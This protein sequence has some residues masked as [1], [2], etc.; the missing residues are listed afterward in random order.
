MSRYKVSLISLSIRDLDAL[1]LL[2]VLRGFQV[3]CLTYVVSSFQAWV[4]SV[5]RVLDYF[6]FFQDVDYFAG[7]LYFPACTLVNLGLSLHHVQ[8]T[9]NRNGVTLSRRSIR[10][11]PSDL[12]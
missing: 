12:F 3:L 4:L 5:S 10:Q 1:G 8:P 11:S 9:R 2:V 7:F 6:V